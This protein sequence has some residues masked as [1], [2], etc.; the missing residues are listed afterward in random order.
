MRKTV[1]IAGAFSLVIGVAAYLTIQD[2]GSPDVMRAPDVPYLPTPEPVVGR[3]LQ[4]AEIGQGDV[5]YDL[6]SGDGRIVIEAAQRYEAR[7]VGV[8]LDP[9]LVR[10]SRRNAQDGGVA[11]LVS[12]VHGDIFT[13][14]LSAA[15]AVTLY[16]SQ[17]VN[18]RLIPQLETLKPGTRIVSHEYDL[19][20]YA[21]E[22]TVRLALGDA[23][24]RVHTI[25]MWRAP[26]RH[27]LGA[28][29]ETVDHARRPDVNFVP[30]P[31]SVVEE[32]LRLAQ[33]GPGETIYDLGSG[34]GRIVIT[35]AQAYG[36]FATG[37]EIDPRL[38]AQSR[39][40]IADRGLGDVARIEEGDLFQVD[41]SNVDVVTLYL[42]PV[43]NRKLVPQFSKLKPG[44]RVIS[45]DFDIPGIE[46]QEVVRFLPPDGGRERTIYVWHAPLVERVE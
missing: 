38:V 3:M 22:K 4:L 26:L 41:L 9:D 23:D 39:K 29:I 15:S 36:A 46:Q 21:P 27:D 40:Q 18:Q 45:H 7:A 11:D 19:P 6:G 14:D 33:I 24:G 8:E 34:D 10:R 25:Y 5:I 16:L 37:F 2:S 28:H 12:I 43:L 31:Q 35:A 32:M 1:A 13:A 20:G 44:A 30:T 42:S 17:E